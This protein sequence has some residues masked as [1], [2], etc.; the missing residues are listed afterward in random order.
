MLILQQT[1]LQ[2]RCREE[3]QMQRTVVRSI[4]VLFVV[5][6]AAL[7]IGIAPAIA[8]APAGA[9][10]GGQ[11]RAGGGRGPQTPPLLMTTTAWEDGG[12]IPDKY[13]QAAGA[14]AV[15]P[16]LNWS[17]VPPGTQSFVL[18]LHDPEPVL[19][20]GSKMDITHWLIWNIPATSTG[21]PEGVAQG[22][23]PDGS[24]QVSLRANAYMGPGAPA[25]PYHHYTFELYALD[26]KLDVPQ[27][28]PPQAADTRTAVMNAMDGHVLGKAV[29]VARFHR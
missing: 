11:G 3:K 6:A 9:Q 13:T 28:A 22:E 14:M 21:L 26:S 25:G 20:K 16:A 19:N 15:S 7:T 12:V 18:L 8:Q 2:Q 1:I 23:L 17:Q 24:R 10:G 29:L 27:G 5:A 4:P